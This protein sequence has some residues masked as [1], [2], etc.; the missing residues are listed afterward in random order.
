M[1]SFLSSAVLDPCLGLWPRTLGGTVTMVSDAAS[2]SAAWCIPRGNRLVWGRVP[3]SLGSA[4]LAGVDF[5]LQITSAHHP[6]REGMA[7]EAGAQR[8]VQQLHRRF[9]QELGFHH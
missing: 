4:Y 6:V 9:L 3:A 2:G 7:V 1:S 5:P 8:L